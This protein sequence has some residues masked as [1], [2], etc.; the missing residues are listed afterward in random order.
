MLTKP[1]KKTHMILNDCYILIFH[2]FYN[3]IY[4]YQHDEIFYAIIQTK[5]KNRLSNYH[6]QTATYHG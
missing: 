4:L 3:Y 1:N 5:E 2:N 6:L